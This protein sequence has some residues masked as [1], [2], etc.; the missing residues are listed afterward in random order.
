MEVWKNGLKVGGG[1]T[2]DE[3]NDTNDMLALSLKK[4]D[5]Y[6]LRIISEKSGLLLRPFVVSGKDDEQIFFYIKE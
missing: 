4:G 1:E 2:R 5:D 6:K 3:N